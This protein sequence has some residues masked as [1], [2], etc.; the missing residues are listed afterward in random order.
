[1]RT[2]PSGD[3]RIR[4]RFGQFAQHIRIYQLLHRRL[5][6]GRP[7]LIVSV[8]SESTGTKKPFC[9]Q[10]SSQSITP[11][12]R[13]GSQRTSR[14]SPKSSRSI[15]NSCPVSI[16]SIRRNSAGSTIWPFEEMTVRMDVDIVLHPSCQGIGAD[17][18][19]A[20][21][22]GSARGL[23]SYTLVLLCDCANDTRYRRRGLLPGQS[24]RTGSEPKPGTGGR[25]P[26]SQDCADGGRCHHPDE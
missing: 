3:S 2:Q 12:F 6:E 14:Y 23:Y 5:S 9:G 4:S 26:D 25:R 8:D 15:S 24:H 16:E 10:E 22:S 18:N 7:V 1:M 17:R 11:A 13:G 21:R 20:G 19:R